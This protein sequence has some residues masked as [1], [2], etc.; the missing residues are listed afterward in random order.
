MTS[1]VNVSPSITED[2]YGTLG[3]C[4]MM[5]ENEKYYH[6]YYLIFF[7]IFIMRGKREY[8]TSI[9]DTL[10]NAFNYHQEISKD[11]Q[12]GSHSRISIGNIYLLLQNF[13]TVSISLSRFMEIFSIKIQSKKCRKFL[14]PISHN[15]TNQKTSLKESLELVL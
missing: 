9:F 12:K 1:V 14:W 13:I 3:K 7:N 5:Y 6:T 10:F 15:L 8:L 2:I 11:L 4:L